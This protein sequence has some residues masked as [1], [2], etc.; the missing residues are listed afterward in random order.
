MADNILTQLYTLLFTGVGL[1]MTTLSLTL[2]VTWLSSDRWVSRNERQREHST[3]L[4]KSIE[5]WSGV[6][7]IEYMPI[8]VNEKRVFEAPILEL[9]EID[10]SKPMHQ[11]IETG[12]P[13][14]W[15][16]WLEYKEKGE[17]YLRKKATLMEN[18]N[19]YLKD[20]V[21]NKS[22]QVW[23]PMI[24]KARPMSL[25]FP[26]RII[27]T[28]L[29]EWKKRSEGY[30]DFLGHEPTL[31][32]EKKDQNMVYH[33]KIGNDTL[34]E[35]NHRDE[36]NVFRQDIIS[37]IKDK[38]LLAQFKELQ[39]YYPEAMN[40]QRA[41]SDAICEMQDRIELGHNIKGKCDYC[42]KRWGL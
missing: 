23:Y 5:S 30:P 13:Y 28:I 38:K 18:I 34:T 12:Y 1:T 32:G 24:E 14:I 42:I 26:E 6:R 29:F 9:P 11:H 8:T 22:F 15:K 17:Y 16:Q 2:I 27:E 10:Y 21:K 36:A 31:D 25:I 20:Y 19:Q 7:D 41:F 4:C 3:R 40:S 39:S 35:I 37:L 33:L